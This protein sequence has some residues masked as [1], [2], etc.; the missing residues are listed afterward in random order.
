[1]CWR[2]LDAMWDVRAASSMW[3][4]SS[5]AS[6]W[7]VLIKSRLWRACYKYR[8]SGTWREVSEMI[9]PCNLQFLKIYLWIKGFLHMLPWDKQ[10][11]HENQFFSVLKGTDQPDGTCISLQAWWE[12]LCIF[13]REMGWLPKGIAQF[14][15]WVDDCYPELHNFWV[16]QSCWDRLHSFSSEAW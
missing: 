6:S 14:M 8:K 13:G 16:E 15:G 2:F 1:M 3:G 11:M 12:N 10:F 7:W 9:F 4:M 5:V